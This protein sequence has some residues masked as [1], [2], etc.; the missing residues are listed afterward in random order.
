[1]VRCGAAQVSKFELDLKNLYDRLTCYPRGVLAVYMTGE[2]GVT[3]FLGGKFTPP[4]FFLVKR[5][6]T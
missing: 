4:V 2:G 3:H 1:M 6:V 5:S